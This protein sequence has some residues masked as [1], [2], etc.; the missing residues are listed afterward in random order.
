MLIGFGVGLIVG[1]IFGPW[2]VLALAAYGLY[3]AITTVGNDY[4]KAINEP[5]NEKAGEYAGSAAVKTMAITF[6]LLS[7]FATKGRPAGEVP[8]VAANSPST[9]GVP[10][11]PA[12]SPSI[13]FSL[14]KKMADA[15]KLAD[16][17]A[18]TRQPTITNGD[19]HLRMR[20][21]TYLKNMGRIGSLQ[22]TRMRR[23]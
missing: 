4:S 12:N 1:I 17:R 22:L 3:H 19:R 18:T 8:T 21:G 14:S 7:P 5:N 13:R 20:R 23:V 16:R 11:A 2:A 10:K 6:A 9:G 15:F